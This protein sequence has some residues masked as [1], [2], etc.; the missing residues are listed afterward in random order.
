[1]I[2][3]VIPTYKEKAN[4]ERLVERT[5]AALQQCNEEFE[6]IIVDDDSPDGTADEV[7]RLSAEGRPWLRVL[8]R[9]NER[10]LST[11]VISGW[12]VA[13]GDVFGCMDADLQHPPEMLPQLLAKMRET[14]ARIVVGSRHVPGGGVSDWSLARRVISWT[15][16]LMAAMILPGTLGKVSDP[17]SGFFL[18]RRSALDR[19]ALNPIG[20]KILLEVLAR[21]DY[22]YVAE[23]PFV[24][25]EREKGGSKMN[26]ATV[27]KYLAHLVRIS[28]ETGEGMRVLKYALVG[29]SGAVVNV[30]ALYILARRLGWAAP[31]AALTGAALAIV[32][33]FFWNDRFT[34]YETRQANPSWTQTLGRFI[35]FTMFSA[36]GV[37]LN[38]LLIWLLN[39]IL[40]VRL[41]WSAAAGVGVAAIWNFLLN[42]NVTWGAWWDR[43]LL[44]HTARQQVEIASEDGLVAIPC[45][46]CGSREV[47][48]LYAGRAAGQSHVSAQA[49]RCTSAEHGDFTNIVQCGECG[50]LY[51]NP[52]EPE[53]EIE[54]QYD[55]VEDPTYEREADGRIRTFTHHLHDLTRYTSPG[56][57][58]DVGCYVGVFLDCARDAGWKTFGAEPSAWAARRANEK[59]HTVVHAPLRKANLAAESFDLVTL[60][61][62]IEHLHDPL[63]QLKEAYRLLRP[64]GIFVLS[65]MDAGCTFARL[66]GRR[67]PWFMR[68]HLYYFTPGTVTK[69]LQAAGFEVIT[70]E[71]HK[72]VISARYLF[73]K[74]GALLGPLAP[75]IQFLGKP[76]GNFF[77][78]V[79]LGDQMNVFARKPG[80]KE[81]PAPGGTTPA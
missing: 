7:R 3:L 78:T 18:V 17:M 4:I 14:G 54:T 79:D 60:W 1:M 49:F 44:S 35:S 12:R 43:K 45:N 2:S 59:G 22:S 80:G 76:L 67:W 25:E 57:V 46:L 53:S 55:L 24:F 16:T 10:D 29:L 31:L 30:L 66:A 9:E 6:L 8:V 50:L 39:G 32:N 15:A 47:R 52:R 75:G 64:G 41:A 36:T 38:V 51:E 40:G 63:G 5:G 69:F 34:F 11:A 21:A 68:M 71:R 56:R 42:S 37:A 77:V 27:W 70:I 65:T 72:R 73:E 13:R 62:V 23:V 58:L 33:N 48:I 61:D 28:I 81:N 26:A 20:Y 74:A 19:A